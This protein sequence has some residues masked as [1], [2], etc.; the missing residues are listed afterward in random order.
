MSKTAV[1]SHGASQGEHPAKAMEREFEEETGV[2]VH[3][4]KWE[5]VVMMEGD[6]WFVTFF[7]TFLSPPGREN[8]SEHDG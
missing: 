8:D 6:G 7:R 4:D 1:H 2:F 3:R 5:R